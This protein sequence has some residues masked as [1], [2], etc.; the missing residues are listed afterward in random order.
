MKKKKCRIIILLKL[1]KEISK[2]LNE[3]FQNYS[4]SKTCTLESKNFIFTECI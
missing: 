3:S 1:L 2:S 4:G